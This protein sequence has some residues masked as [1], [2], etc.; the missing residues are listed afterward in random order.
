MV[1]ILDKLKR[2]YT[3]QLYCI[4]LLSEWGQCVGRVACHRYT[5]HVHGRKFHIGH[6]YGESSH[7]LAQVVYRYLVTC[8][9]NVIEDGL[10]LCVIDLLPER[11]TDRNSWLGYADQAA[12]Q[13]KILR[14]SWYQGLDAIRYLSSSTQPPL[15]SVFGVL[16]YTFQNCWHYVE[17][18][19]GVDTAQVRN[20]K[21]IVCR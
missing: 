15:T 10:I 7:L 12:N 21:P 1:C 5:G 14:L 17:C 20:E 6:T 4:V 19:H 9:A 2:Y 18:V 11:H 3:S 13:Y 16:I 8:E